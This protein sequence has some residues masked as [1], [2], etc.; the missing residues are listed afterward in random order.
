[1]WKKYS[2]RRLTGSSRIRSRA[3]LY[4]W[5]FSRY[6]K[7]GDKIL[8]T[9]LGSGSSRIAAWDAGLDFIGYEIDPEYFEAQEKRFKQHTAQLSMFGG[10]GVSDH[11]IHCWETDSHLRLV[12]TTRRRWRYKRR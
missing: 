11:N 2:A 12:R 1:M 3:A 10:G 7:P 6:A 4:A 8:D 9:H 5:I